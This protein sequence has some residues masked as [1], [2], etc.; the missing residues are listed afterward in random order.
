MS[1]VR[2][3]VG[4]F[5]LTNF[6]TRDISI[7]MKIE[8]WD[9]LIFQRRIRPG[10][11]Y[12]A[13]AQATEIQRPRLSA[14]LR[15]RALPAERSYSGKPSEVERL[16]EHFGLTKAVVR[17]MSKKQREIH[18]EGICQRSSKKMSNASPRAR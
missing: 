2:R 14:I 5:L 7:S 16:A 15:G 11:G 3:K 9:D 8:T 12:A 18:L 6:V 17:S 13:V 4:G 10:G 1:D